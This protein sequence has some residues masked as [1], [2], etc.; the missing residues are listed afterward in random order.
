MTP[1]Q[2]AVLSAIRDLT[3][4]DV[5]P[6]LRAIAAHTGMSLGGV[7]GAVEALIAAGR[8]Y[9]TGSS[10]RG[11]R[12]VGHFDARALANLSHLELL[13]L[14]DAIDARLNHRSAA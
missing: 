1:K 9:R 6:S 11:I 12:A 2:Q 14:R 10:F 4:G 7:H 5:G 8:A 3:H 13:T